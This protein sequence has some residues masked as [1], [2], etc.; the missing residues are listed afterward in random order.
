[1]TETACAADDSPYD[2]LSYE[3]GPTNVCYGEIDTGWDGPTKV[4][5]CGGVSR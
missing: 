5:A 4:R 1:M 3:E 2:E